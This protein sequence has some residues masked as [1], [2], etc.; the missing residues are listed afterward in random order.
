MRRERRT[1]I[2][3]LEGGEFLGVLLYE[4]G[5]LVEQHAALRART[6]EAPFGFEC[7]PGG[8]DSEV[9]VLFGCLGDDAD[10]FCVG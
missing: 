1:I 9:D 8:R 5:E 2:E 6:I 10:G 7:L 3:A 4:R